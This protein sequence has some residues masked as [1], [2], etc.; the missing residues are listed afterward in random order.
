MLITL[1][2]GIEVVSRTRSTTAISSDAAWFVRRGCAN[3]VVRLT[4][5]GNAIATK[6][7]AWIRKYPGGLE[8]HW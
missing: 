3:S 4:Y 6:M 8:R 7:T 5:T 1:L 2:T